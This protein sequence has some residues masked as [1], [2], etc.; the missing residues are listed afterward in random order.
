MCWCPEGLEDSLNATL[1]MVLLV[2][3]GQM[4]NGTLLEMYSRL[5][6]FSP[7]SAIQFYQFFFKNTY[8]P[9]NTRL[10]HLVTGL[11]ERSS[12]I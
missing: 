10:Y 2:F 3:Y 5:Q 12:N 4:N 8:N 9:V 11:N 1:A 6:V 7:I